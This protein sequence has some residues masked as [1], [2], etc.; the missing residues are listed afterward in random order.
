MVKHACLRDAIS[1][2]NVVLLF[3]RNLTITCKTLFL[4]L[5]KE[6]FLVKNFNTF[7]FCKTNVSLLQIYFLLMQII[8]PPMQTVFLLYSI[9]QINILLYKSNISLYQI[10]F[11]W[12]KLIFRYARRF[13]ITE[14]FF[15][16]C[17]KV[18]LLM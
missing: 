4:S 17:K 6:P 11:H 16:L 13:C 14:N 8:F 3:F 7:F 1:T 5:C 10:Y 2:N 9:V 12:C 15:Q 18:F